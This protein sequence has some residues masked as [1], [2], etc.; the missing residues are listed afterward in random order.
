MT[1][2]A[3][4]NG[5]RGSEKIVVRDASGRWFFQ[6]YLISDLAWRNKVVAEGGGG[7]LRWTDMQ[8]YRATDPTKPFKYVLQTTSKSIVYH[9]ADGACPHGLRQT[10]EKLLRNRDRY[11]ALR[12]C[13]EC[14]PG[15]DAHHLDSLEE[16]AAVNV[17]QDRP[18]LYKCRTIEQVIDSLRGRDGTIVGLGLGLLDEAA[19]N[20]PDIERALAMER[21]L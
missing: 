5:R 1:E 13:P 15:V 21:P 2:N 12:P 11:E 18:T 6:G 19:E 20:D 14:L 4:V 3:S 8:L 17:E 16:S 10:V 7:R 9:R